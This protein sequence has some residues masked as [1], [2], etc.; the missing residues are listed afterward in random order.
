M[1]N[2]EKKTAAIWIEITKLISPEDNPR[3]NDHV[4]DRVAKSIESYGFASPIVANYQNEILAG[5][6]RFKAAK[7]LGLKTVPVRQ[8]NLTG[9]KARLYRIADNKLSELAEWNEDLLRDQ[10][11][12]L[13]D[14][15]TLE[16]SDMGFS[17]DELNDLLN[18]QLIE[19]ETDPQEITDHDDF[20]NTKPTTTRFKTGHIEVVGKQK[21][22][23]G[24]C[25]EVLKSMPDGSVDSIVTD[26]PYQI[27]FMSKEWDKEFDTEEWARQC[28][29]VL[30][31]GGHIIAFAATRTIHRIMYSLENQ[32]F[33]IRDL[34]SWLYFSGFPKSHNVSKAIDKHFGVEREII[35]TKKSGIANKEEKNRHTIGASKAVDVDITKPA[36]KEA[37]KF[38]G[39]GTALKPAQEP[40]VL[41]RK[42]LEKGLS[43]AQNMMK[44]NTGGLNIDACR[45]AYGDPC[46]VGPNDDQPNNSLR[47]IQNWMP[48]QKEPH[49]YVSSNLG[50]WPANI[51]QCP[52]PSRG[53][54]EKGLE[55]HESR[56]SPAVEHAGVGTK[57]LNNPRA[58]A[59]RT[60]SEVKNFHPTVKPV[61][62]MSWLVKLITPID[63]VVVDTFCG[64]GTTLVASELE[65]Y[66]GIGIEM[67]PE[68]CEI[69][70]GRVE[71]ATK[72]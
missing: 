8:I 65:K 43:I 42:P 71:H 35:G 41:C 22:I 55:D 62:L 12:E 17:D 58:G 16:L 19:K 32:G 66:N 26:P 56:I 72:K 25:I 59:G 70:Y 1:E 48:T 37:I 30:K 24:D 2:Q 44:H 9:D 61:K 64:S 46:W 3:I 28:L 47:T 29:R 36:T 33:E 20:D 54:K 7:K 13:H 45:F 31:P 5:N 27:S 51:Y 69:I 21:I 53:E 68:Y 49:N 57:A 23:C 10:L 18:D 38:D 60:A 11:F 4:V 39:W 34:I 6:T 52:K 67:N 63:G 15:Y 40:A 50:R 14:D